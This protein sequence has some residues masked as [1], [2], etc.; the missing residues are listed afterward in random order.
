MVLLGAVGLL[1]LDDLRQPG[2]VSCSRVGCSG[3]V[4]CW[5]VWPWA[6]NAPAFIRQ[7]ISET[8]LIAIIGGVFRIL[9]GYLM[10][11]SLTHIAPSSFA[12]VKVAIDLRVLLFSMLL[13]FLAGII[14]SLV[15]AIQL[16]RVNIAPGLNNAVRGA[17]QAVT[18]A[19]VRAAFVIFSGGNLARSSGNCR[20]YDSQ[21]REAHCQQHRHVDQSAPH[22][23]IPLAAQ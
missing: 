23:G 19:K 7:L 14:F 18:G 2:G 9:L 4:K 1:L 20:P 15:P 3:D 21:L 16:S 22:V 11:P 8:M 13:T 17:A 6:Q 5:Y 10:L 12:D